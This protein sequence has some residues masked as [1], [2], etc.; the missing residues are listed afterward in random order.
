VAF[1]VLIQNLDELGDDVIALER[2]EQ[3]AIDLNR[4]FGYFKSAGQGNARLACAISLKKV[5]PSSV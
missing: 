1:H 3:A 2:G 4:G 5:Q